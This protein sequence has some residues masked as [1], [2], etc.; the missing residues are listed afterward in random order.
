M[1]EPK[2]AP[3]R[4]SVLDEA[5]RSYGKKVTEFTPRPLD[6]AIGLPNPPRP[7]ENTGIDPRTWRE[8]RD[9]FVN[10]DKHLARR[11]RLTKAIAKPYYRDWS[12]LKFSR[13]KSFLAPPRLFKA[14][15]ALYFPNLFGRTLVKRAKRYADTT[16]VLM[17]KISVVSVFSSAWGENQ[18]ATF[19]S[20]KHNPELHEV[21]ENN[22]GRAQLV[23]IN[24]EENYL[25]AL[26]I[27][28]FIPGLRK[29][30]SEP[31]WGKYF[32]V[33]KGLNDDIKDAI[34]LLNNKVGYTYLLDEQCKIRWA[35]SG[36]AEPDERSDLVKGV[37]RLLAETKLAQDS[38]EAA[39]TQPKS[40][41]NLETAAVSIKS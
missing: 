20:T 9:D 30:L 32:M 12:N 24:I 3:S 16:P 29:R 13:G 1:A 25:K 4:P 5:P 26:I 38:I 27:K 6:R 31:N 37:R 2:L 17:G 36:E 10:Y 41:Q 7:G 8:R 35:G 23:H 15:R 21:L 39:N 19:A 18:A 22:K 40:A 28:L 11:E 33:Q 14:E 34:G